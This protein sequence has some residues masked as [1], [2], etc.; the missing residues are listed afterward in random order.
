MFNALV[1]I[2]NISQGYARTL[3]AYFNEDEPVAESNRAQRFADLHWSALIGLG[4]YSRATLIIVISFVSFVLK[5]LVVS[6]TFYNCA[7]KCP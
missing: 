4:P 1:H 2:E 3:W 7:L 5:K 6:F